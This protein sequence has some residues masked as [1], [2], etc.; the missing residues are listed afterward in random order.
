[1]VDVVLLVVVGLLE[2]TLNSDD[3]LWA[4]LLELEVGV[5]GDGHELGKARSTEEGMVDIGEVNDLE[6]ERLLAEVV[7]LA[8]GDAEPDAPARGA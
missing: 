1:M 5:V 4:G 3:P 2:A 6:G 8:K 7:W